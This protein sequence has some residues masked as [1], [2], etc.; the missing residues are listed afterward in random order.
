MNNK[1]GT[2]EQFKELV[3][4]LTKTLASCV[5]LLA[6][7]EVVRASAAIGGLLS[8]MNRVKQELEENE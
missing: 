6:R 2:D 8:T 7:E 5:E 3:H 4:I 1:L